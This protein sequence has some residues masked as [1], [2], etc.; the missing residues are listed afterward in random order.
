MPR[1]GEHQPGGGRDVPYREDASV[2][3][4]PCRDHDSDKHQEHMPDLSGGR[5]TRNTNLKASMTKVSE[6][7]SSPLP[8]Q[9]ESSDKHQEQDL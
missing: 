3:E 2:E 4:M 5:G 7:V 8:N 1:Q 9:A 6:N